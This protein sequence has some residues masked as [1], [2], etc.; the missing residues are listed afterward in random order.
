VNRGQKPSH[1]RRRRKRP[2]VFSLWDIAPLTPPCSHAVLLSLRRSRRK[3]SKHGETTCQSSSTTSDADFCIYMRGR[4]LSSLSLAPSCSSSLPLA[5][6]GSLLRSLAFPRPL[7]CFSSPTHPCCSQ[8]LPC[9]CYSGGS[10][11]V[12]LAKLGCDLNIHGTGTRST[13][14]CIQ[15]SLWRRHDNHQSRARSFVLLWCG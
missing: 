5:L 1:S 13:A 4:G 3:A 9:T 14:Y 11:C 12:Q 6:T 15:R 8:Q 7:P 2:R 10:H